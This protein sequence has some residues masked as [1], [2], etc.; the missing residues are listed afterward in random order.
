MWCVTV[1]KFCRHVC[2]LYSWCAFVCMCIRHKTE[3]GSSFQ[4]V[5]YLQLHWSKLWFILSSVMMWALWVTDETTL[6]PDIPASPVLFTTCT[7]THRWLMPPEDSRSSGTHPALIIESLQDKLTGIE[8]GAK[9]FFVSCWCVLHYSQKAKGHW[10]LL[11][12]LLIQATA[13]WKWFQS[14][15]IA[16]VLKRWLD[17]WYKAKSPTHEL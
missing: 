6:P 5:L 11:C 2:V 12:I 10:G 14:N 1:W 17:R 4:V 9:W 7:T 16:E 3:M 13:V 8:K 15:V